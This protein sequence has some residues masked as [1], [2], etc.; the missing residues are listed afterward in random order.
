M[1]TTE[2]GV[3]TPE[4]IASGGREIRDQLQ[5]VWQILVLAFQKSTTGEK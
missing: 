2:S 3:G 5:K 1:L 4:Q